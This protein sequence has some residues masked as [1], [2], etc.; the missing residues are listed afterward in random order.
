MKPKNDRYT[1]AVDF[2]G[3]VHR[4]DTGWTAAHVIPD[5][6]VDGAIAWL[7]ETIQH[8]DV[9][10]FSTRCKSFR[11][12]RAVRRYIR[13]HAG[14]DRWHGDKRGLKHITYTAVKP[15]AL[16]YLDDRAVRFDGFHFPTVEEIHAARPWN[17]GPQHRQADTL[18]RELRDA[19][20]EVPAPIYTLMASAERLQAADR[21]EGRGI[22]AGS[23]MA[24]AAADAAKEGF[25]SA[26]VT[27]RNRDIATAM[28]ILRKAVSIVEEM[29]KRT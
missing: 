10:I 17:K 15:A 5:R 21:F 26:L 19:V 27:T 29:Q 4:Y 18:L 3:V 24:R 13:E 16:I 9:V 7:F 11:G 23:G 8:L 20:G 22:A 25:D 1:A 2:D 14:V 6:P 28:L 12:R